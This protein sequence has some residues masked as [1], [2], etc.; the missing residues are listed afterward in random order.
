MLGEVRPAER[1]RGLADAS[2]SADGRDR[3]RVRPRSHVLVQPFQF[4]IA[5]DEGGRVRGQL[6]RNDP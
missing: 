1:E 4:F 2:G 5:A 3:D 6:G